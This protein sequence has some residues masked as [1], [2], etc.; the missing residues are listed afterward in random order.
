PLLSPTNSE[1]L[2]TP[3]TGLL[4]RVGQASACQ[5]CAWG[6]AVALTAALSLL[7]TRSVSSQISFF[8][9]RTSTSGIHFR[10][11]NS[12]SEEKYLIETMTGGCAFF[13]YDGDGLLDMFLVNGAAIKSESGKAPR[14]DKSEPRY[15]NRLYRNL[16]GGR[17]E[18]VT[19][20]AGGRGK[21]F[22][23]GVAVGDYDDDGFPDVYV[24][25]YGQNELFHNERNGTFKDVTTA[26]GVAGRGFALSAAF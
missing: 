5:L 14:I 15:W 26:G 18:D 17:F 19:E 23:L 20:K 3:Q 21:G 25:N 1:E 16:G 13:D 12:P 11:E 7:A 9:D 24:T 8:Q 22:G 10:L 6:I 2:K 4:I